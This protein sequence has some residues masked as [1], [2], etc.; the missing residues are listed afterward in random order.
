VLLAGDVDAGGVDA[1]G[2]AVLASNR[3]GEVEEERS[4]LMPTPRRKMRRTSS[5][6]ARAGK[7][8]GLPQLLV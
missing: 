1:R 3:R 2:G 8:M 7:P 4:E 5:V 6:A